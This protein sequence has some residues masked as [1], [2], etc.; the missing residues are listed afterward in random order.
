M[1][2]GW[3]Q[4]RRTV[5]SEPSDAGIEPEMAADRVTLAV[6]EDD[7]EF[8]EALLVPGLASAGFSVDGMASAL[9]LYRAMTARRYDLVLLDVGLP[10]DDGFSIARHL[11]GLSAT[12]GIVMLTG[13]VSAHDRMRGLEAGVDAY[14]TKPVEMDVLRATLRNLARR[15]APGSAAPEP[16]AEGQ[17]RLD[18]SGWCI[19]SPGGIEVAM[20]LAE[21][22]VMSTLAAAPG[23]E[24]RRERLIAR[25]VE[26]VH[27]FD[28]H[29][30]EMLV[31]RLRKKCLKLT[32][33]E[34]PLRAV[35]GV[36]YVLTW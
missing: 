27:D 3:E 21:K 23:M 34:L 7:E 1:T 28:P 15:V 14:L 25:L 26:N 13:Y 5:A 11:R 35:R 12:V 19:V 17:W 33:Q 24:V 16:G 29:R 18:D 20:S 32:R 9:D 8:R 6:V 36:G 31:Y 30:L 4:G 10:D 2:M 22:Q